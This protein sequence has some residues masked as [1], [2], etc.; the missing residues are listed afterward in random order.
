MN[1][2]TTDTPHVYKFTQEELQRSLNRRREQPAATSG[3]KFRRNRVKWTGIILEELEKAK[4]A[5]NKDL[6]EALEAALVM[7]GHKFR[8]TPK[9]LPGGAGSTNSGM[10]ASGRPPGEAKKREGQQKSNA[11]FSG[12][13]ADLIA[14]R[15]DLEER[16]QAIAR[17]KQ[18]PKIARVA[19]M[20]KLIKETPPPAQDQNDQA[21]DSDGKDQPPAES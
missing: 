5:E 6:A 21:P 8:A 15:P 1:A 13:F 16:L 2:E 9:N 10:G 4:K 3:V 12:E 14:S 17:T 19:A 11:E 20:K 7:M 18:Q